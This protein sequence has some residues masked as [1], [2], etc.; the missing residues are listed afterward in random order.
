M[1]E[2]NRL[3]ETFLKRH[4]E[5]WLLVEEDQGPQVFEQYAM[6]LVFHA[7]A[8]IIVLAHMTRIEL[9]VEMKVDLVKILP[10]MLRICRALIDIFIDL[11]WP[12]KFALAGMDLIQA[13]TQ[14]VMPGRNASL[15]QVPHL[16]EEIIQRINSKGAYTLRKL[17]A[18][19]KT[20]VIEGKEDILSTSTMSGQELSDVVNFL[21]K[22]EPEHRL[23]FK[24]LA[25]CT[26]IDADGYGRK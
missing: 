18:A 25:D 22:V 6:E 11:S 8:F 26:G 14:A 20:G 16:N 1:A 4:P 17:K 19:M 10:K 13:I 24:Q 15:R 21:N 23:V 3:F 5:F 9:T 7:K 2:L 12:A